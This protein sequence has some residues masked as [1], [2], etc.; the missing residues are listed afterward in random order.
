M[1]LVWKFTM[2]VTVLFVTIKF[3]TYCIFLE[4]ATKVKGKL[5]QYYNC[6]KNK[7]YFSIK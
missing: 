2:Y 3:L 4:R 1:L 5:L 6:Y 7:Y